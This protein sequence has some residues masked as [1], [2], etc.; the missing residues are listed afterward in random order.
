MKKLQLLNWT[1][2]ALLAF[3]F[4][5]C[6][7]EPLEG[8]F[9]IDGGGEITAEEGQFVA[10]I[11]GVSFLAEATTTLYDSETG[12]IVISGAKEDGESI[13]LAVNNAGV[14]TF[15]LTTI[16]ITSNRGVYFPPGSVFNPFVTDGLAGG[17]GQLDITTFDIDNLT[18]SGTFAMIGVRPLLDADGNPVL[19]GDGNPTF[20]NVTITEGSFNA[21]PITLDATTGG[22][23]VGVDPDPEFFAKV[24][25]E[26]FIDET[27]TAERVTVA[28]VPMINI[29]AVST[30]GAVIRIDIP[31]GLGT[32]TFNFVDPIS[33]GTK[34]IA[35]YTTPDGR[36]YTSGEFPDTGSITLTEFGGATGK[37]AA[38]F[39]FL[40]ADVVPPIDTRD[41]EITEGSF[42]IDYIND[43]G[44]VE[45]SFSADIDG[46]EYTPS[47]IEVTIAPFGTNTRII[48]TTI[49][50]LS[51]KSLT[52]SFPIDIEVGAHEMTTTPL[53]GSEKVGLHNPDI[54][55]SILFASEP[56]TLTI[57]SYELSSGIVEATFSFTGV[58]PAG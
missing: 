16:D 11:G 18:I 57:T 38:T 14:G 31:E 28:G 54:G 44:V 10:N 8:E 51:N 52:I 50:A 33:D 42:N 24:E 43:S 21:I 13:F 49:D 35:L 48:I 5:A 6:D 9:V 36:T 58:D 53:D 55:N 30:E 56:G 45:N 1:L 2:F 12:G 37:L 40:A 46:V 19:D 47:S 39:S 7:N 3:T 20:E 41:F 27:F 17:S 22:G 23:G 25:G 32:G 15:D 26:E 34:L 29:V 4:S